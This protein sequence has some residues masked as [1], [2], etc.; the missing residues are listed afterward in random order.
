M[1]FI[2][3]FWNSVGCKYFTYDEASKTCQLGTFHGSDHRSID[4]RVTEVWAGKQYSQCE[5]MYLM[6]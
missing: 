5:G 3:E 1:K 2:S 6:G 4:S